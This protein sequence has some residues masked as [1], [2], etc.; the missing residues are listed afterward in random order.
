MDRHPVPFAVHAVA[1]LHAEHT[2]APVAIAPPTAIPTGVPWYTVVYQRRASAPWSR[3]LG[4]SEPL[5]TE[6]W[7]RRSNAPD[8]WECLAMRGA[9]IAVYSPS[10]SQANAANCS[11]C[12]YIVPVAVAAA[13]WPGPPPHGDA[14]GFASRIVV[15]AANAAGFA[16]VG[17]KDTAVRCASLL[18]E[19]SV[20]VA[21]DLNGEAQKGYVAFADERGL[22]AHVRTR[23]A[24]EWTLYEVLRDGVAWPLY[25]DIE[26]ATALNP[27]VVA[28]WPAVRQRA[29]AFV[30]E[31]LVAA[32]PVAF[33]PGTQ[34]RA[35]IDAGPAAWHTA[36]ACSAAK[37]STHDVLPGVRFDSQHSQR[38]FLTHRLAME[39]PDDLCADVRRADGSIVRAPV[40]D[41]NVGHRDQ[42]LRLN[43]QSKFG[44]RRPLLPV[45]P[46]AV[47][48]QA[49][50]DPDLAWLRPWGDLARAPAVV[51]TAADM[52]ASQ[53]VAPAVLRNPGGGGIAFDPRRE[54]SFAVA[55]QAG[56]VLA[57]PSAAACTHFQYKW[58]RQNLAVPAPTYPAFVAAIEQSLHG[59]FTNYANEHV[60]EGE[61]A[62]FKLDYD[63]GDGPHPLEP[64]PLADGFGTA[65]PMQVLMRAVGGPVI[66]L[67]SHAGLSS[68]FARGFSPAAALGALNAEC[69]SFHV[70]WPDTAATLAEMR[71]MHRACVDALAAAFGPGPAHTWTR[72]LDAAPLQRGTLRAPFADKWDRD[73]RAPCGRP[74][75]P[76]GFVAG[77][78]R[79]ID[80]ARPLPPSVGERFRLCSW[81]TGGVDAD[82][83][84]AEAPAAEFELCDAARERLVDFVRA[85]GNP[86]ARLVAVRPAGAGDGAH[87][88]AHYATCVFAGIAYC[89]LCDK[90]HSAGS[91]Q[92]YAVLRCRHAAGACELA[93]RIK[94]FA[95]PH[96]RRPMHPLGTVP[97]ACALHRD[98]GGADAMPAHDDDGD[99]PHGADAAADAEPPLPPELVDAQRCFPGAAE[100]HVDAAEH[101]RPLWFD[102]ARPHTI[103]VHGGVG[104][105]KT[106]AVEQ[107]L[108]AHPDISVLSVAPSRSLAFDQHRRFGPR[109]VALYLDTRDDDDPTPR[110][111]A[112]LIRSARRLIVS[113]ESLH[114]FVDNA[115][116]AAGV[117]LLI[118]DEVETLLS[119][120][121]SA[122]HGANQRRNWWA[123][124][125]LV[126]R[127]H[128]V[129]TL[130]GLPTAL[131][132]RFTTMLR[133]LD[134]VVVRNVRPTFAWH[135][136][137]LGPALVNGK[138]APPG[139]AV[140]AAILHRVAHELGVERRIPRFAVLSNSRRFCVRIA[141]AIRRVA[142]PLVERLPFEMRAQW[143]AVLLTRDTSQRPAMVRLL[144]DINTQLAL[145]VSVLV[146]S[147]TLQVGVNITAALFEE[148]FAFYKPSGTAPSAADAVQQLARLRALLE[149]LGAL[150]RSRSRPH[151]TLELAG[152]MATREDLAHV[153]SPHAQSNVVAALLGAAAAAA[154]GANADDANAVYVATHVRYL[155]AVRRTSLTVHDGMRAEI[156]ARLRANGGLVHIDTAPTHIAVRTDELLRSVDVANAVPLDEARTAELQ[157]FWA[158]NDQ[159]ERGTLEHGR[160]QHLVTE[161]A[162]LDARFAAAY[163]RHHDSLGDRHIAARFALLGPIRAQ[164]YAAM[165]AVGM[166]HP[167]DT[168]WRLD[169]HAAEAPLSPA[170]LEADRRLRQL[171]PDRIGRQ[172]LAHEQTGALFRLIFEGLTALRLRSTKGALSLN[173]AVLGAFVRA[174]DIRNAARP[175][176]LPLPW[177]A[178]PVDAAHALAHFTAD[179]NEVRLEFPRGPA[180][181]LP[182]YGNDA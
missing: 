46:V 178:P 84:A 76:V 67:A 36:D 168:E 165:D 117:Q 26:A 33:A 4:V 173:R 37:G 123:L 122:T 54:E 42:L 6:L 78:G 55:L 21:F 138:A 158:G 133:P 11:R 142:A 105:G 69:R 115:L 30:C 143:H 131:S 80:E 23:A 125:E 167:L 112:A 25:L 126:R 120:V 145:G 98:A 91:N 175:T 13:P 41:C 164:L 38:R 83:V 97:H 104:I 64:L 15:A 99:A 108:R 50:D 139:W 68:L 35:L 44:Q 149:L 147:P 172:R 103:A 154:F 49:A 116:F 16:S 94:C 107:V 119:N 127:A 63:R 71:A 24:A 8:L 177:L 74:V 128:Q 77:D 53:R 113:P 110:V 14:A 85:T 132:W 62:R 100:Y 129:I 10:Q 31:Q 47:R 157:L 51:L 82:A 134:V 70:V 34:A 1:A 163:D 162:V 179:G 3:G 130:D 27:D 48:D 9:D 22:R 140:A 153:H 72:I 93:A 146:A 156:I 174:A 58:G 88:G 136:R 39:C 59:G 18:G 52:V 12:A 180:F 161:A 90:A 61:R 40:I 95:A 137:V 148:V 111:N 20:V 114:H 152:G 65:S 60:R 135:Y 106:Y 155:R 109:G 32:F 96:E 86:H 2:R 92:V 182:R 29:Q 81:R 141:E 160:W 181:S 151:V 169:A 28:A 79:S 102:A 171:C 19:R 89:P 87:D 144:R 75:L 150:A 118:V 176:R 159:M 56:T 124:T 45:A 121:D 17:P 101:L 170:L 7:R 43:Y 57:A 73:A 66:V 5:Y 166:R